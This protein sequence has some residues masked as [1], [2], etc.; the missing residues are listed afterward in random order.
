MEMWPTQELFPDRRQRQIS[1]LRFINF[2][3]TIKS[4]K[5]IDSKTL[6]E[7]STSF[8][9]AQMNCKQRCDF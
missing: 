6:Y 2:Y 3:N 4:H 8:S 5:G 9:M 1:L 7:N